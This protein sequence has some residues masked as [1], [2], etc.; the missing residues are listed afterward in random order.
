[1]KTRIY[2]NKEAF[3]QRVD[4]HENG[5]GEFHTRLFQNWEDDNKTNVGCYNCVD[6]INC[7]NCTEV[8]HQANKENL[9]PFYEI[10]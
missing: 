5:V 9:Y 1:M 2:K 6:C 3:D 10:D 7:K 4:W 8:S